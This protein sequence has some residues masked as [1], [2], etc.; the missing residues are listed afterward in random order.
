MRTEQGLEGPS[1]HCCCLTSVECHLQS[2]HPVGM[3]SALSCG[4]DCHNPLLASDP[5]PSWKRM[6]QNEDLLSRDEPEMCG[7]WYVW[8]YVND[9]KI[10]D[11]DKTMKEWEC[12]ADNWVYE[13]DKTHI[14]KSKKK[15]LQ[16]TAHF[17]ESIVHSYHHSFIKVYSGDINRQTTCK[18][19][20]MP[21]SYQLS[22][23]FNL[24]NIRAGSMPLSTERGSLLIEFLLHSWI[25]GRSACKSPLRQETLVQFPKLGWQFR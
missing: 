11:D 12:K 2:W 25:K 1:L 6:G 24:G 16:R 5:S 19:H 3:L 15:I 7:K 9:K 10:N 8:S 21:C 20:A 17:S 23:G 22:Q 18:P 14:V 13:K 4:R